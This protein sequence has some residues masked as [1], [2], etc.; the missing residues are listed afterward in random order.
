MEESSYWAA[1]HLRPQCHRLALASLA[2]RGYTVYAPSLLDHSLLRGRASVPR[3]VLLFTNY[4]FVSIVCGQWWNA[5]HAYGVSRLIFNGAAPV[6]V[7]DQVIVQ[8]RARE[9][10]DGFIVLPQRPP[11][12]G[13]RRG[14]RIGIIRGAFQG[15]DGLFVGRAPHE[16]IKVLLAWL[17]AQR[18]VELPCDAIEVPHRPSPSPRGAATV[19]SVRQFRIVGRW[20]LASNGTRWALQ[21]WHANPRTGRWSTVSCV[22][23]RDVL[24]RRLHERGAPPDVIAQLIADLPPTF[25]EWKAATDGA[26]AT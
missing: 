1:A 21:R 2:E 24:V 19:T 20:A 3:P 18:E 22:R 23:S 13:L 11:P 15:L 6:K 5:A 10:S 26:V 8:L 9:N 12:R 16:R 4:V 17:G 7:P 25:D 14:D